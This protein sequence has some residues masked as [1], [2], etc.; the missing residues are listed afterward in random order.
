MAIPREVRL[1]GRFDH[2][3]PAGPRCAWS[4]SALHLRF[5]GRG[6]TLRLRGAGDWLAVTIDG[7]PRPPLVLAPGRERYPLAAGLLDGVHEAVVVKRTEPLVGEVQLLGVDPD[8]GTRLVPAAP[9]PARRLELVGDSITA[10]YGV[11]GRDETCPFSAATE[12][13]TRSFAALTAAALGAEA[14]VVAW[15]GRG[16]CRNYADEPGEP[17]PALHGRT[18][19]A[20]GDSRW[21]FA[22]FVPA[23]VVVNLGTNDFGLGRPPAARFVAAYAAFLRHLRAVYPAAFLLCVLGPMLAG[24]DRDAA[25]D[26]VTEACARVG[27]EGR[28]RLALLEVAPQAPADGYGCDWHPSAAT[29]RRVAAAVV[30]ALRDAL[31]W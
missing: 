13:Y 11:L 17:M 6:V 31:G 21:D 20:R 19:P 27:G 10:G 15:S 4:G 23:A 3:D 25:W 5:V 8:A 1:S 12:D 22:R 28:G 14:H 24:A 29:Q 9:A 26:W 7:V 2:G 16:V 30:A 18:L